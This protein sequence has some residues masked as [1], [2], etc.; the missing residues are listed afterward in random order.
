M[1]RV[2]P[3][4]FAP[5][6]RPRAK[7]WCVLALLACASPAGAQDAAPD[8]S[9]YTL[10]NPTP[11][12]EL[13]SFSTDRPPKANSPYTVDAGHFQYET[14]LV[15]LGKGNQA[16][17]AT[18]AATL[19]D[20]T[21]KLGLSNNVDA[22]LQFTPFEALRSWPAAGSSAGGASGASGTTAL[23]GLGDTYARLKI[24]VLGNDRGALAVALL[25]YLKLPTAR[26]GLGNDAL[27]AGVILPVSWSAPAG[28]TVIAM[29]EADY[30]KNAV[31]S[32]HHGVVDFL[33]NVSHGLSTRWS[34]Y[35]EAYASHS[36]AGGAAPVYTLDEAL[37]Y[38]ITPNLQFD[39]GGNFSLNAVALRVQLYTGLSE[40]F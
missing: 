37:T 11:E 27:E 1:Q 9:G 3:P 7:P 39:L 25:P 24:N 23:S 30:L 15:V 13:R 4:S 22:E 19:L 33:V 20:P 29:P 6:R 10:F 28:F 40:R 21:L 26:A 16:G 2:A 35:T 14:D 5:G 32:G 38:A 31:G 18:R 34:F 17:L 8:K 36:F 12:A